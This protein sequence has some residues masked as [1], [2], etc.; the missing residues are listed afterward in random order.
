MSPDQF[1]YK[2][3]FSPDAETLEQLKEWSTPDMTSDMRKS[4]RTNA[5]NKTLPEKGVAEVPEEDDEDLDVKPL[6]AEDMEQ[7]RQ[8]A[9]E[10]GFS[11][12]K[13]DGF[14]KGYEE[15]RQQGQEDGTKQGLAE[16]KKLGL[17]ESQ[18]LIEQQLNDLETMLDN[19]Q[20]P[21]K[22]L[23]EQVEH[24]LVTL[25]LAMAKAVLQTEVQTNEQVVLQALQ[26]ATEALPLQKEHIRIKFHPDDL[27]IIE[28]HFSQEQIAQRHWTLL[29]EPTISRG[30][31]K[32]ET[33]TS[34]VDRSLEQRIETS[35]AHF[36][37]QQDAEP[38]ERES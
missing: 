2:R 12:G 19:L 38:T 16:G 20:Q 10:A 35:L 21:L 7:L 1:R 31:C 23:D 27:A 6:T 30:G 5:L 36:I 22:Q 25:A 18:Q 24:Q 37:Q 29:A 17:E 34:A 33:D 13:E 3:P 15:G 8:Q 32:L 11:E 4:E 26:Q 9:Y 14:A 28:Q